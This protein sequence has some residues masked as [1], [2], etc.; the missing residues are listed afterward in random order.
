[1]TREEFWMQMFLQKVDW[2]V[3]DRSRFA[4]TCLAGFDERFPVKSESPA[5][6]LEEE[7]FEWKDWDGALPLPAGTRVEV[8]FRNGETD[9]RQNVE[10]WQWEHYQEDYD[11]VKYRA[12][13]D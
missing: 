3:L 6:H 1:M 7:S 13:K 5:P 2:T 10:D 9:N 12:I 4:D 8:V 11:I